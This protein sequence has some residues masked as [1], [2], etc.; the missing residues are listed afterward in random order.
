[1]K[2]MKLGSKP[3]SFQSDGKD[4][5]FL[6][7]LIITAVVIEFDGSYALVLTFAALCLF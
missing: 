3:D 2:F 1:M 6:E 4:I 5:R 7:F